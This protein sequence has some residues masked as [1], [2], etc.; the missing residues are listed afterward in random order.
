MSTDQGPG[1]IIAEL[2]PLD[3]LLADA[4]DTPLTAADL[5]SIRQLNLTSCDFVGDSG[6]CDPNCWQC[7]FP[8][9]LE[10]LC[11]LAKNLA[12]A[13]MLCRAWQMRDV[14]PA[15]RPGCNLDEKGVL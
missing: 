8:I 6:C 5:E 11:C 4:E 15:W 3:T 1:P 7:H 13:A 14:D 12:A 9:G 10:N 2:P